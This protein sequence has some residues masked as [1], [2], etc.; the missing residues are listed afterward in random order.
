VTGRFDSRLFRRVTG[1]LPVLLLVGLTAAW[2]L[3]KARTFQLFGRLVARVETPEPIVALTFDD[4]PTAGITDTLITTLR[5]HRVHA[6]FFVTG[7]ELAASPTIGARL[8]NAGHELGNHSYSHRRML[9]MSQRRIRDE[10]ERTDALI[11]AA[12]QTGPIYFR[13]PYGDKLVGLPWFL[14]RSGRTTV[15]WSIEPD[16]YANVATS[17]D[18]IVAYVLSRVRPG[19]IIILHVWYSSRQTSRAAVG[20]MIDSLHARGYRVVP[21]RELIT[22]D[23]RTLR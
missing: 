14:A 5:D 13:P 16:S 8:V 21:V 4:G 12:G 2:R 17:A 23:A 9:F 15:M 18:R 7:R 22:R 3:E 6:T 20:P 11:R 10:V 19:S 1:L